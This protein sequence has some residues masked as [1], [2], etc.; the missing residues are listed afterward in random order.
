MKAE[1]IPLLLGIILIILL[2]FLIVWQADVLGVSAAR[3]EQDAR[4]NQEIGN[5]WE[6]AQAVN[7]DMCAMLFY[8]EEK[9]DCAYSIYLSREGFSF[10]YFFRQG[11]FDPYM[12]ESVKGIVFEDKGIALLSLNEDGVCRIVVDNDTGKKVISVDPEKPFAVVLPV[13]CSEITMYDAQENV[14]TLYDTYTGI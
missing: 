2:A 6:M 7:D 14:V 11:G 3:L 10:G 12:A 1:K 13:D 5:N 4:E 8:D 9:D